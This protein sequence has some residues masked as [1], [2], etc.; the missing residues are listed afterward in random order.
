MSYQF[1]LEALRRYRRHQEESKQKDL[2][3][4]MRV[5]DEAED[6]LNQFIEMRTKTEMD[7]KNNQENSASGPHMAMYGSFFKRLSED[8]E[9][10]GLK[11]AKAEQVCAMK[12]EALLIA[13]QKRKTL[14]KLKQKGLTA[15]LDN[16]NHE[17]QKFINE[18]AINRFNLNHR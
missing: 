7:L 14:D 5:R 9:A 11:V 13:M 6:T 12:R 18:M 17:E 10:Q 3:E 1:K 2:A 16:L 4:A 8:I 15:Y